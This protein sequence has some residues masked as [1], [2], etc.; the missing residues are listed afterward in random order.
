MPNTVVL[1]YST[2]PSQAQARQTVDTLLQAKLAACCNILSGVESHYE[3]QGL[4]ETSSEWLM[5]TKTTLERAPEAVEAIRACHPY[6]QPAIV[7]IPVNGGNP[8]FLAW[9]GGMVKTTR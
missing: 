7:Q 2:H 9:V 3:W 4:R 8:D 5:F 6:D 1:I